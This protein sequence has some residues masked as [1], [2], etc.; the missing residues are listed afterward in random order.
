MKTNARRTIRDVDTYIAMAPKEARPKLSQ[1]R[2]IV[3]A[4]APEADEIISYKMPY[5][6]YHG[7]MV[8]FAAFKDHIGFFG[9]LSP[10]D[11]IEFRDY[12]IGKGTIRFPLDKPLPAASITKLVKMRKKL[13][14]A[15][16]NSRKY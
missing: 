11:R 8:G 13:N 9:A 2:Q 7:A 3:R 16:G 1:L 12:E 4:A 6:K 14:E 10:E 15:R 5:Y